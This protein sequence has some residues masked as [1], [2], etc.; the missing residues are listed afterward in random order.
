MAMKYRPSSWPKSNTWTM[1]GWLSR[2]AMR[3]L[4]DEHLHQLGAVLE[5]GLHGLDDDPPLEP[6]RALDARAPDLR[7]APRRQPRID[8]VAAKTPCP[9]PR[10]PIRGRAPA[11]AR[12]PWPRCRR[13]ASAW[14]PASPRSFAVDAPSPR[15]GNN[16]EA[17]KNLTRTLG[18][19]V[20]LSL[21]PPTPR[22]TYADV[23]PGKA[24]CG[25]VAT[26]ARAP[27]CSRSCRCDRCSRRRSSCPAGM[28]ISGPPGCSSA[29]SPRTRCSPWRCWSS[30]C[31]SCARAQAAAPAGAGPRATAWVGLLAFALAATHLLDVLVIWTPIYGIDVVVRGLA[32]LVA[33]A[34]AVM[35]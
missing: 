14:P 33:L 19:A 29:R 10:S 31:G 20:Q 22:V 35:A 5:R 28:P 24:P 18:S 2:P 13:R 4:G 34:A 6:G 9:A 30:A 8:H 27:S 1:F 26:A 15:V 12:P 3:G 16:G 25:D 32:R 21:C 17:P 7:H 23:P 11:P